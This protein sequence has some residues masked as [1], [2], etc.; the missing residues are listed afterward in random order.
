MGI[1]MILI[2][3]D[4]VKYRACWSAKKA[5]LQHAKDKVDELIVHIMETL[6][7]EPDTSNIKVFMTGKTNFRDGLAKTAPYKANREDKPKPPF[8]NEVTEYITEKYDATTSVG[9]EADDDI[10]MA[11][12][13]SGW[14]DTIASI[15]K[16][17]MQCPCKI[18]NW[19]HGKTYEPTEYEA[20][21]HFYMQMLTGDTVDN[22]IGLTGVG[23]VKAKKKLAG[24]KDEVDMVNVVLR[25]YDNDRDRVIENG[26]LLWL[27]R[28]EGEM[29]E[30][31]ELSDE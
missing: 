12:Y 9:Q 3:G 20:L 8:I 31:K 5:D 7:F 4:I 15:D 28:T 24:C 11:A 25:E 13:A 2:D 17:F 21:E 29:W 16:D 14:K 6:L 1:T 27:R 10:V 23:P 26:R 30:I 19:G 18:Y 22:I